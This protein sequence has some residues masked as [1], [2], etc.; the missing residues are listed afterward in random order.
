MKENL[1]YPSILTKN[2]NDKD[3]FSQQN[4]IS[5]KERKRKNEE[6]EKL[7]NKMNQFEKK[8]DE[9]RNLFLKNFFGFFQKF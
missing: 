2:R 3:E 6:I 8:N 5:S 7:N 1:F 9:Y 4:L